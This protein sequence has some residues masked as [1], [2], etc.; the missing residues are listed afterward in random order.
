MKG[1]GRTSVFLWR[2]RKPLGPAY[3]ATSVTRVADEAA[4][5]AAVAAST[6]ALDARV[7][8]WDAAGRAPLDFAGGSAALTRRGE[9]IFEYSLES[10]GANFLILSQVWY[11][12]WRATLDG[13]DVPLYR[14]NHALLGLAVPP[15]RHAL[16]LEMTSPALK[17]G[18][19]LCALGLAFLAALLWR[20]P[21]FPHCAFPKD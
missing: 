20:P 8:G 4:S 12:G 16:T 10:R 21:A 7:F 17:A 18:L 6:S 1:L 15:G 3:F 11:P 14:T 9:N 19:V 5:L 13:K 2:D